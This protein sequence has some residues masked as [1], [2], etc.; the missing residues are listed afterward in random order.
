[1]LRVNLGIFVDDIGRIVNM[2]NYLDP[3]NIMAGYNLNMITLKL[4]KKELI[5]L[6]EEDYQI[7]KSTT[8]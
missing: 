3:N 7:K 8:N 1:M 5:E 2:G 4:F 6:D